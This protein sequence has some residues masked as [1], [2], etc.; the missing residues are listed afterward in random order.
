MGAEF[1]TYVYE[2]PESRLAAHHR[3]VQHEL[4]IQYGNDTYAG[5]IGI[6]P[7]GIDKTTKICSSRQEAVELIEAHHNKWQRAMA[8]AFHRP[9]SPGTKRK[10]SFLVGGWCAS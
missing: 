2:G 6:M 1:N 8:V 5:H 3:R 7:D 9:G 10:L 4:R